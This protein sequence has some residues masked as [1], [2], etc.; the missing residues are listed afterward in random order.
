MG[1]LA[2]PQSAAFWK[3]LCAV[4]LFGS[5][6]VVASGI[7]LNSYEIVLLRTLIGTLA[8]LGI[9][10]LCGGRLTVFRHRRAGLFLV[11]SGLIMGAH[12]MC[13]YEAYQTVG[14]S[15]ATLLCYCGPVLVMA[16][17][18]ALFGE[19]L[20]R[21]SMIGFAAVV[22]G[23]VLVSW[24]TPQTGVAQLGILCGILSAVLYAGMI[25]LNKQASEISGLENAMLQLLFAFLAVL[26]F[27]GLR[28]GLPFAVPA[29]S[30]PWIL[31]LGLV[32][33][34]VGCYLYFSAI[35]RLPVQTVSVMGYLEP[36]SAVVFAAILLREPL[37][38]SKGLGAVLIIGG[39]AMAERFRKK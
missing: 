38:L 30:W 9:F 28:Q 8:M 22:L 15:T 39:A 34:G 2:T 10:V 23:A 27:M 26:L 35:G 11:S 20:T 37:Q 14:V 1:K 18:P 5:N 12:W 19:R 7:V 21:R 3:Y 13:L 32:N 4:L 31:L 6:G 25:I 17:S 16:L 29:E 24:E 36:V 33:T